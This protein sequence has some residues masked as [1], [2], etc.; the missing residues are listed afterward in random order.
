[1]SFKKN[2]K[3]ILS[4]DLGKGEVKS[5]GPIIHHSIEVYL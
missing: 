5:K 4:L 2:C 1:M 3:N